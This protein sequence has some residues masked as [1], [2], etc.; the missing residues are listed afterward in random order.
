MP[1]L[2]TYSHDSPNG[3]PLTDGKVDGRAQRVEKSSVA[4]KPSAERI[5]VISHELR[6]SL[7]VVRNAA[8]LLR[9]NFDAACIERARTLIERH[10]NQMNLHIEHLLDPAAVD[11][12]DDA[13]LLSYVDLRTI[14]KN[15]VDA[16]ASDCS[17]RGHRLVV[18]LPADAQW[19]HA[20]AA[21]LERVFLN[22]LTNAA[23]YTPG[24]GE[25]SVTLERLDKY[26]SIRI[27]DT[28]IGIAPAQLS[29]I[30]GMSVQV[31]ATSLLAEGGHGIGLAVVR[32][33]VEMHGGTVGVASAGL[34]FGSEFNVLLPL[35]E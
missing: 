15:T 34:G 35:W 12:R 28:G 22:L 30:F 2:N 11:R 3:A 29:R 20:D 25:I 27:R 17:R 32:D 26:A 33:L 10:V 18:T 6:N 31:D 5:A 21:G 23:K 4:A 9:S 7:A 8:R 16:I 13:L 1:L 14:L 19:V 24:G